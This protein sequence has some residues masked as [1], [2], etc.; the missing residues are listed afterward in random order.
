VDRKA[1]VEI[2]QLSKRQKLCDFVVAGFV[3]ATI[4]LWERFVWLTGVGI[5]RILGRWM[6]A[7]V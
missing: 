6:V 2:C 3:V 4:F 1:L 5:P 7:G